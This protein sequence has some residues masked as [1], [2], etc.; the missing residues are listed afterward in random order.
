MIVLSLQSGTSAD[1][2]DVAV[3]EVAAQDAGERPAVGLRLLHAETVAWSAEARDRIL[4]VSAGE[5]LSA[6]GFC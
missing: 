6:G 5:P 3:V 2:I 1:G 4:A